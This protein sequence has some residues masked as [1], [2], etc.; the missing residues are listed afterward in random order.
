[1]PAVDACVQ[2]PTVSVS[3]VVRVHELR[4]APALQFLER[5]AKVFQAALIVK[6]D[7][8]VRMGGPDEMV[9]H[10]DQDPDLLL[11]L[12]QGLLGAPS[13]PDIPHAA[14]PDATGEDPV[15]DLD[16]DAMTLFADDQPFP[17]ID[18]SCPQAPLQLSQAGTGFRRDE[19]FHPLGQKFCFGIPQQI[20]TGRIERVERS[21]RI[22]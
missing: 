1:M 14:L 22:G 3:E 19:F 6:V 13:L 10:F 17:N 4:P 21:V 11:A 5:D 7:I 9:D 15:D 8:P 12:P 2:T 20:A 16:G 18:S